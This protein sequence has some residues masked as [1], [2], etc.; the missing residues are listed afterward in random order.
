MPINPDLCGKVQI[1]LTSAVESILASLEPYEGW[2]EQ[3]LL[4]V[5]GAQELKTSVQRL[6]LCAIPRL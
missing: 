4:Q 5:A 2:I 3:M 6:V 1:R